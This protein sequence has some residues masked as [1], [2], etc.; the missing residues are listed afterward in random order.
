MTNTKSIF[1]GVIKSAILVLIL[2]GISNC[3]QFASFTGSETD[4]HLSQNPVFEDPQGNSFVGS[5][6]LDD[7]L[8]TNYG[9]DTPEPEEPTIPTEEPTPQP[10]EP[11]VIVDEPTPLPPFQ[12]CPNRNRFQVLKPDGTYT[13]CRP[14][15]TRGTR[16]V[17]GIEVSRLSCSAL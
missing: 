3:N 5:D 13:R 9:G 8:P 6:P 14:C 4:A 12:F 1:N 2:I 17:D 15:V 10:E 7:G 16:V 11:T